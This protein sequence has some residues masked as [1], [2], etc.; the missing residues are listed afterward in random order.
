MRPVVVG[1]VIG[2]GAALWLSRLMTSL[3]FEITPSDPMTYVAVSAALALTGLVACYL[4]ARQ[5]LRVD[6]V[7]AL[8]TE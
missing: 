6:P 5:V 1:L 3:L 8:R 4:P 2:L 7:V